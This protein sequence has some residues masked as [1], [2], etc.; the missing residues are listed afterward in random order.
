[1]ILHLAT[2]PSNIPHTN[3][4]C[5]CG[6]DSKRKP[7]DVIAMRVPDRANG[8]VMQYAHAR[9][10]KAA[11]AML[12]ALLAIEFVEERM[13]GGLAIHTCPG[14][15]NLKERGHTDKC[16]VGTALAQA[17]GART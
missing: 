16:L 5:T 6:A 4:I 7:A 1:M 11:P 10:T 2:C 13:S 3:P 14:C 9:I 12:N 15:G 17:I 8:M